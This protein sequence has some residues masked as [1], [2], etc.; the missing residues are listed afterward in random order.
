MATTTFFLNAPLVF[1]VARTWRL[2][3]LSMLLAFGRVICLRR[4]SSVSLFGGW[5]RFLV[6]FPGR[7]LGLLARRSFLVSRFR[8]PSAY[9]VSRLRKVNALRMSLGL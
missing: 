9:D 4:R 7:F 3:V 6:C 8:P 5:R 1:A 2:S